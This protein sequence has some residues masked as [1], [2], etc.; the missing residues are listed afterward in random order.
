MARAHRREKIESMCNCI[1]KVNKLL[2]EHN[3]VINLVDT[4]DMTTGRLTARM[5][6]PVRRLD[7]RKRKEAMR[8]F[9]T[10][11]PMCGEKYPEPQ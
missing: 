3:S 7:H 2:S 6:I 9:A 10:Y 5:T 11:C 4:I 8:V 1:S